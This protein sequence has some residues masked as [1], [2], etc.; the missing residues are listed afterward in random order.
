[1]SRRLIGAFFALLTFATTITAVEAAASAFVDPSLRRWLVTGFWVLKVAVVGAFGYFLMSRPPSRRPARRPI[2]FVACAGA[3]VGAMALG[4]PADAGSTPLLV[5]GEAL[6]LASCVWLLVSVLALGRCFGILPEARGLVTHGPYRLVRHPVYLGELGACGG[7]LLGAPTQRN[8]I[9][10]AVV[11]AAQIVRMRLEEQAL[12]REFPEYAAYAARTPRLLPLRVVLRG[13]P[14]VVAPA[15]LLVGA[16]AVGAVA[17]Q[18]TPAGAA[19]KQQKKKAKTAKP[20]AAPRLLSPANAKPAEALPSFHWAS[21][22]GA[23]KYEFQLSADKRF[24][25]V[26]GGQGKGSFQTPNTYAT[27]A[28]TVADGA[29]Y[30]RVRAIDGS[31]RIGRWSAVRSLAKAWT[32]PAALLG[33]GEGATVV[34]PGTPLVL[35]WSSVRYAYKYVV[36]IATDPQL[37]HSAL[38]DQKQGIETSGT[39]F[40]LPGTLASGRYFWGVTPLDS[41]KHPGRPSAVGSFVWSWPTGTTTRNGDLRDDPRLPDPIGAVR[42]YDPQLSWDAVPGAAQYQV[43]VNAS[44]DFAPGSRVCCDETVLGTSL[45]PK[46]ALPNNTYYWRVRAVDLD[47]NAGQW[48]EGPG[49]TRTPSFRKDFAATSPSVPNLRVWDAGPNPDPSSAVPVMSDPVVQ[50][51]S[52]PGAS[53]YEVKVVPTVCSYDVDGDCIG[54]P[55][56]NPCEWSASAILSWDVVTATPAWTALSSQLRG[57]SPIGTGRVSVDVGHALGPGWSYCVEV[58]PIDRNGTSGDVRGDWTQLGGNG[59]RAFQYTGGDTCAAAPT[60]TMTDAA[61]RPV[62]DGRTS[63]QTFTET[64]PSGRTVTGTYNRRMPVFTW[65]PVPNAC[66]YFVVVARDPDFTDVVDVA[67]TPETAYAPRSSGGSVTYLD[68]TTTYYWAVLPSQFAD[69]R[70]VT[71]RLED[72]APQIFRKQSLS[73]QPLEPADGADVTAQP[74]FHWSL[75]RDE[76]GRPEE[77][78][79]YRLQVDADPTFGSPID[80]VVTDSTAFTSASTYP[81]DTQLYWRVRAT[82]DTASGGKGGLTW[83]PTRTFTRRLPAPALLPQNPVDGPGIPVFAWSPVDGAVSYDMHVEQADGTKRDFTMRSTAFTPVTFYGTGVWRWQVRAN[84][85]GATRTVSSGFTPMSPFARRINP[86]SGLRTTS[87]G[88]GVALSWDPLTMARQYR[89]QI[90]TTDSFSIVIEDAMT[91][92]TSYAPRMSNPAWTSGKS[93][94]WRVAAMDEG[95]NLGAWAFTR[96]RQAAAMRVRA[97]GSVAVGRTSVVTVTVTDAKR[98]PIAAA[99][100]RVSGAGSGKAKRTSKKGTVRLRVRGDRAGKVTLRAE[101][102]GYVPKAATVRVR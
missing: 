27:V 31:D 49:G 19:A 101:K 39:S 94:Y 56:S 18:A 48:N 90:S 28:K 93:L 55:A 75:P 88:S 100:V 86:A 11:L 76:E 53:S 65:S 41:S 10:A 81:A 15:L 36:R 46:T 34:Y 64:L 83:S 1:M 87:S 82:D 80:D 69:G 44:S 102:R 70:G 8:V 38:G 22:R 45:S 61:Y 59:A 32:Q 12:A 54:R 73:P 24:A 21:V 43:E 35:R 2:A 67:L 57:S 77:V 97:R 99:L 62:H 26:V 95:S 58:R 9:A 79:S 60:T 78:R 7:L 72:N 16:L 89:V 23:V 51:D 74:S 4:G 68:E 20:P 84:F 3:I 66:G 13:R 47:G 6:A 85:K 29:Y 50:W 40:A 5:A 96:L 25:S 17:L 37:A 33:P 92:G 71:S 52:V 42:F 14:A 91:E 63:Q 98:R 30:W